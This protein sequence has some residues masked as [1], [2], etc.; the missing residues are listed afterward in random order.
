MTGAK[1]APEQ[2]PALAP[3]GAPSAWVFLGGLHACRARFRFP[4]RSKHSMRWLKDK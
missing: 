4:R 3:L 2:A 1:T